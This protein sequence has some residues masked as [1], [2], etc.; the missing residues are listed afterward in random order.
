M[1]LRRIFA[2]SPDCHVPGSRYSLVWRNHFYDGLRDSGLEVILPAGINFMSIPKTIHYCW[3]SN[4]PWEDIYKK[5]FATWATFLPDYKFVLWDLSKPVNSN[6]FNKMIRKE[7]WAFA[8]DYLRLHALYFHGGIY[9]DLD[10]EVV[11]TF[12]SLLNHQCFFGREDA[13]KLGCHIIGSQKNNTFI[14]ECLDYYD[15][16]FKLKMSNP[17]T[18]PRI[19][20]RLAYKHGLKNENSIQTLKNDISIYSSSFFAPLHYS[21]RF[22]ENPRKFLSQDS[23]CIH[24]WHHG[25]SWLSSKSILRHISNQPWLFMN[26]QDWKRFLKILIQKLLNKS[27]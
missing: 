15:S 11:K 21:D 4:D 14:K 25:W 3:L 6:F 18:M 16:S 7:K 24:Y 1:K 27:S 20:T 5:C 8:S 23:Y 19:V 13:Q 12:D 10:I 26:V 22:N 2:L 17:P 9:L